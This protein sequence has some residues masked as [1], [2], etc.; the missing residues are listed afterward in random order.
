MWPLA[1]DSSSGCTNGFIARRRIRPACAQA[2]CHALAQ[3]AVHRPT[4]RTSAQPCRRV[5]WGTASPQHHG[6][7]VV[8]SRG[9]LMR[10]SSHLPMASRHGS[11]RQWR[12][13]SPQQLCAPC[14]VTGDCLPLAPWAVTPPCLLSPSSPQRVGIHAAVNV[15]PHVDTQLD[16]LQHV[17][18]MILK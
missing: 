11:P 17:Q 15:S 4:A 6:P 7:Y 5:L 16:A 9:F 18:V 2:T 8:T 1:I 3:H 14:A 10:R 13:S 12:H